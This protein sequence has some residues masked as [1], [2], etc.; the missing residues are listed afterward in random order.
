MKRHEYLY[1]FM[2]YF[3]HFLYILLFAG[4]EM[5]E[6]SEYID[7]LNFYFRMYICLFLIVRFNPFRKFH[8]FSEFD[9]QVVFTSALLILTTI[10]VTKIRDYI[11]EFTDLI[12]NEFTNYGLV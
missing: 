1:F 4:F 8:S 6:V 2:L 9:R 7:V 3:L 5:Y 12:Q 11:Q 10:G